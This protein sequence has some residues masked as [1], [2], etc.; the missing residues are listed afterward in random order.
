[1]RI[2]TLIA[3]L[4]I[5]APAAAQQTPQSVLNELLATERTL[6]DV[7]AKLTPAEGIASLIAPDGVLMTPRGPVRG[8][9]A[10][11][12]ALRGNPSNSGQRARWRSIISGLSADGQQGFTLGYLDIDGGDPAR[13][14]RRYLAYWVKGD[15]GWR[16]AA[17]KQALRAP[18]EA[19]AAAQP[20]TLPAKMV[21]PGLS[22]TAAHR[23]SL[24][25]AE[26]AFSGRAQKVGLA[27]AFQ[28]NGRPDAIHLAGPSGIAIGLA[29]IGKNFEQ[30][31]TGSSPLAWSADSAVVAS[32]GDLGMTLGDIR[33]N[34]PPPEGQPA[35][36]S[37]FTIWYRENVSEPWRYIVE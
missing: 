10:A 13:G 33:P 7:A 11:L 22:A 32:S 12:A 20:P 14:H 15:A 36:I 9:D 3:T 31:P 1:M 25:A 34:S 24:I 16:V 4:A 5:A 29:A 2:W 35:A 17:L 6:S 18:N 8:P 28:E 37:F 21:E 30:Q 27:Q 26:K 23:A 19:E